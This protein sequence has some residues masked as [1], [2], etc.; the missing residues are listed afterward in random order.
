[1][2]FPTDAVSR[3]LLTQPLPSAVGIHIYGRVT[4]RLLLL[5]RQF[6]TSIGVEPSICLVSWL[7]TPVRSAIIIIEFEMT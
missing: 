7:G 6:Y 4:G 1:M 2:S 3:A 5:L